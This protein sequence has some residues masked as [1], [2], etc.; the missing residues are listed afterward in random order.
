MVKTKQDH[1]KY[2]QLIKQD[3]KQPFMQYMTFINKV[4]PKLSFTESVFN[5]INR[6][7]ILPNISITY[8][9][10]L[11]NCFMEPVRLFFEGNQEIKSREGTTQEDPTAMGAYALGVTP[12][13]HFLSEFTFINEHRNKEAAFVDDLTVAGKVSKIKAY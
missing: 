8:P 12:L 4:K 7:A 9:T 1:S 10:F 3:Q 11:A 6:E 13:I 2:V 5:S